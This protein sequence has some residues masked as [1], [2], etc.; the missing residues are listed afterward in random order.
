MV[1][2]IGNYSMIKELLDID[3][4]KFN[5]LDSPNKI[6][7]YDMKKSFWK[8]V[9][10]WQ[11]DNNGKH[12]C[13]MWESEVFGRIFSERADF[14]SNQIVNTFVMIGDSS[15]E[16][17]AAEMLKQKIKQEFDTSNDVFVDKIKLKSK[18]TID[19]LVDEHKVLESFRQNK[20]FE[21]HS[22]NDKMSFDWDYSEEINKTSSEY[23]M[24]N[25]WKHQ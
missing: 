2:D 20:R 12:R 4:M 17:P 5:L 3:S 24:G 6:K 22:F 25:P 7:I 23:L 14:M 9:T 15:H 19:I 13:L 16:F 10:R 21:K 8:S 11:Y 1:K 18:P